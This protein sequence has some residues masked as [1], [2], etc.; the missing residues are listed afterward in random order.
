[1]FN[2]MQA[3]VQNYPLNTSQPLVSHVYI[4][5][6]QTSNYL[7]TM[8]KGNA[9]RLIISDACGNNY[10]TAN[11]AFIF[12]II[13]IFFVLFCC[14]FQNCFRKHQSSKRK[15]QIVDYK[16]ES[17][18]T[19]PQALESQRQGERERPNFNIAVELLTVVQMLRLAFHTWTR[20]LRV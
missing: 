6:F 3:H 19:Q 12:P 4:L 13:C 16:L 20:S 10:F 8:L 2:W 9:C 17:S 5:I 1:M 18:N 7:K 15:G 11:F 14:A